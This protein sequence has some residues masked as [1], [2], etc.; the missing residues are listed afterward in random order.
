MEIAKTLLTIAGYDPTGG[1]GVI[2]DIKVFNSLGFSG[3]SSI[4]SI[5][6]QDTVGVKAF[7]PVSTNHF[8]RQ[9]YTLINDV[10]VRGAKIGVIGKSETIDI[11]RE[12]LER[13]PFRFVVI[14]PI[15]KSSSGKFFLKER[16]LIFM[17]ERIF[18][19]STLV[20]PNIEEASVITGKR[21]SSL[22]EMEDSAIEIWKKCN[23]PVLIK[24]GHLQG[25]KIDVLYD[26]KGIFSVKGEEINKSVHGTGCIFSSAI[27]CY[28][29]S[30]FSLR[31]SVRRGK[32]FVTN[33][34]KNSIRLGKGMWVAF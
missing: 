17:M 18:P 30:G 25:E 14:D 5:V 9:I 27:L 20:T 26:G 19:L 22:K 34:I 11:I 1:A 16:D 8:Q 32:E 2:R 24:G 7:Y 33:E 4:T 31:E 23:V 10:R 6:V 29:A 13:Q 12:I 15:L 21:I 3:V 28:L